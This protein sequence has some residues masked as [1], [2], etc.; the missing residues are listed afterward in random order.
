MKQ[1]AAL[2][3]LFFFLNSAIAQDAPKATGKKTAAAAPAYHAPLKN[4]N[5]DFGPGH[6]RRK[7]KMRKRPRFDYNK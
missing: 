7:T 2:P 1:L 5:S 3:L 6:N 4:D